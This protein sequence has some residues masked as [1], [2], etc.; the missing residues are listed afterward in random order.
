M[1]I[2]FGFNSRGQKNVAERVWS[3]L[4]KS[5]NVR[6]GAQS[7][8]MRLDGAVNAVAHSVSE[9]AKIVAMVEKCGLVTIMAVPARCSQATP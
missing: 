6:N 8:L 7:I 9:S 3:D 4:P 5:M 1:S 2:E